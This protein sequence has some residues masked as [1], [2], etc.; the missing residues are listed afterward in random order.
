MAKEPDDMNRND[1]VPAAPVLTGAEDDR[2][3]VRRIRGGDREALGDLINSYQKRILSVAYKM[4]GEWHAAQDIAQDVFVTLIEKIDTFDMERNFFSWIYR[5][6][7]NRCIDHL[8]RRQRAQAYLT[9]PEAPRAALTSEDLLIKAEMRR[10][11]QTLLAR[12]PLP[13]RTVLIL[14]DIEGIDTER[15]AAIIDVVPATA[16]WRIFQARKLF[17]E[18]WEKEGN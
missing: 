10:R 12:L 14:R 4:T 11:V 13:Y 5:V 18:L 16:R 8:R 2:A 6:A 7:I 9:V 17:R 15:I 3:V 1:T